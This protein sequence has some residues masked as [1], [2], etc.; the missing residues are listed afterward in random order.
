M[1]MTFYIAGCAMRTRFVEQLG[2]VTG[3]NPCTHSTTQ[4]V[5]A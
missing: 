2:D 4:A 5:H 1:I 3:F